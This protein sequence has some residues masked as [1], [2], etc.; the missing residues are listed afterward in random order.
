MELKEVIRNALENK[1]LIIKKNK[2]SRKNIFFSVYIVSGKNRLKK[3][4]W[5]NDKDLQ[6]IMPMN[7]KGSIKTRNDGLNYHEV[8]ARTLQS[9]SFGRNFE[10]VYKNFDKIYLGTFESIEDFGKFHIIKKYGEDNIKGLEDYIDYKS[11]VYDLTDDELGYI[12]K[13]KYGGDVI[14]YN[15]ALIRELEK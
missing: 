5:H 2:A 13:D 9:Y 4:F 8:I 14:F 12:Y 11:Y 3:I 15:K 1:R 6:Q 7:K 10:T